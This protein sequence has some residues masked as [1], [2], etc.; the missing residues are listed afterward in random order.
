MMGL[1]WGYGFDDVPAGE[2]YNKSQFQFTL[3]QQF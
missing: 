3:G 1:D 2:G